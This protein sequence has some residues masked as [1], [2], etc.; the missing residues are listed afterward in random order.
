MKVGRD[1]ARLLR[2]KQYV[3][4]ILVFLPLFFSGHFLDAPMLMIAA[5]GFLV[6]CL[7]ASTVYIINDIK[8]VKADRRHPTKRHRPIASGAISTRQAMVVLAGLVVAVIVLSALYLPMLASLVLAIYVVINILYS[9]YF[10]RVPLVDVAIIAVGF[11]LRLLFGGFVSG[12]ELSSWIILT[13]IFL[14]LFMAIGKRRGE[15]VKYSSASR[16]V[17]ASY[18]P[19]FLTNN[20]YAFM[21]LSIV[22]Y[23]LWASGYTPN[24]LMIATIPLVAFAFMRYSFDIE[25]SDSDG[26]PSEIILKD[27]TL[28]VV[29][30][31]VAILISLNLYVL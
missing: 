13:V 20:M 19:N 3:K 12:I 10:K 30:T 15:L 6:F 23:S 21:A 5:V 28:M 4:N 11:Y 24:T 1:I 17:L 18:T 8:D 31:I 16:K 29:G 27:R 14:S 9:C 26:D 7:T 2:V 25:T 22:F